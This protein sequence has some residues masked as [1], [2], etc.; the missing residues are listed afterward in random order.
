MSVH[1]KVVVIEV[2]EE[3]DEESYIKLMIE[4]TVCM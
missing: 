3:E 1:N 4:E 2:E